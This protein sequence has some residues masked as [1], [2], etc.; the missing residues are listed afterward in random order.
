MCTSRAH[1]YR[2]ECNA[3]DIQDGTCCPEDAVVCKLHKP[4]Y[5][6]RANP[7]YGTFGSVCNKPCCPTIFFS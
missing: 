3:T 6:C 5:S 7:V 1:A 2:P 4:E